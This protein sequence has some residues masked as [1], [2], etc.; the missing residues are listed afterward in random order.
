LAANEVI[1]HTEDLCKYFGGIKALDHVNIYVR[2]GEILGII[3]PNGAGK[4][5]LFNVITGFYRPTR[6]AVFFVG[7]KISG[8]HPAKIAKMGIGRT[9][10]ITRPFKNLT[11]LQDVIAVSGRGAYFG[12]SFLKRYRT[13]EVVEEALRIIKDVGLTDYVD[14][15]AKVL[16]I[17]HMRRLEIARALALKPKLLLLDEPTAGMS[18]KEI[19]E[20]SELVRRLRDEMGITIM[21]VEHNM[22]V[23]MGLSDRMYVL[24]YGKVIA[25]GTPE[26]V[27]E[28]PLVIEAYLGR[29]HAARS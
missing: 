5:T 24:S 13:P 11:V 9:F 27:R 25:E 16:P 12:L 18:A 22:R 28:N 26:E 4:T 1:L 21:L 23:A 17:G 2:K 6:G 14:Q 7:K 8:L 20:I 3:G 29:S 10:Q 19:E 15:P